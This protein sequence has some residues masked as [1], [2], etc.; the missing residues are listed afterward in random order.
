M[1]PDVNPK[2]TPVWSEDLKEDTGHLMVG[3]VCFPSTRYKETRG[4]IVDNGETLCEKLLWII[5]D[6]KWLA[7]VWYG[8]ILRLVRS[9]CSVLRSN[10]PLLSQA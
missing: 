6:S 2:W 7:I 8:Q 10:V 9:C 1:T 3:E 5:S 4:N